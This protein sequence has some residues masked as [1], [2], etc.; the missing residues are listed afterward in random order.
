MTFDPATHPAFTAV[1][2]PLSG[3]VSWHLDSAIAPI[4]RGLYY[5]NPAVSADGR[6]LWFAVAFPPNPQ[7]FAARIGLDPAEREPRWFPQAACG[8]T[9]AVCPSGDAAWFCSEGAVWRIDAEGRLERLGVL[10]AEFVAGRHIFRT[11]THLTCSADGRHLALDCEVGDSCA[12]ALLELGSGAVTMV[13]EFQARHNHAQFSPHDPDQ[14]LIAQDQA[15]HPVSGRFIHHR[16]RTFTMR[17][18]GSGYRCINPQFPCRPYH[19]ACHEW[20]L[21]DGRIAFIEYDSGV[22]VYDPRDG[23]TALLWSEPLCH[24]HA[25]RSARFW[26]ADQSPYYWAE[27]PCQVL[28]YDALTRTRR[29]IHGGLPQPPHARGPWHL[30]PHPQFSPDG[31]FVVW[32][33]TARGRCEVAVTPVAQFV[34]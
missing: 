13:Q 23:S 24:A 11:A 12:L 16:L 32:M 34:G 8:E 9:L 6:W 15:R 3:T 29:V 33:S 27:K 25:D 22:H 20:W 28:F 18:D 7:V 19:G 17:R 30:D 1:P 26:C 21:A 14:L 10:P 5:T 2:D 4:Q 31:R